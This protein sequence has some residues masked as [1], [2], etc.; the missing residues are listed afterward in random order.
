MFLSSRVLIAFNRTVF[1]TAAITLAIILFASTGAQAQN[2]EGV[3][4]TGTFGN[5]V[6]QGRIFFPNGHKSAM[7]PVVKLQSDN[8]SELKVF[9]DSNGNFRFTRLRPNSYTIMVEGGEEFDNA[10]ESVSVGSPGPVPAQGNPYDYAVPTIYEVQIYLRPKRVNTSDSATAATNNV[11]ANIPQRARKFFNDGIEAV[12]LGQPAKA[13]EQFKAAIA[14]APKFALA[15]NEMGV[16]Y[17][18]LGEAASAAEAFATALGLGRDDFVAHLNYGIALLNLN[19]FAE[20]EQQL[21]QALQKN[22]NAPT[23]HYYLALTLM[24]RKDFEAAEAEFKTSI[25][26]SHDGIA[27]AHKYLGGI[28]WERKQDS[29]AA[30][31][32]EKYLKLDPKAVDAARIRETIRELRAKK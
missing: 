16:Q 5:E 9:A 13:I 32:L 24:K 6:I 15:Y 28:Y 19:K 8:S 17:L 11:P 4:T 10:Y 22:E 2:V 27:V 25:A 26:N 14:A 3:N 12:H 31:E 29:L 30:D 18:K 20:A 23:I 21:R 1:I 7:R